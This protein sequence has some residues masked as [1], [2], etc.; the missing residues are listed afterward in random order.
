MLVAHAARAASI[1]QGECGIDELPGFRRDI[2][3]VAEDGVGT[4]IL[5]T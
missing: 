4:G 5:L 2:G 3:G 1:S